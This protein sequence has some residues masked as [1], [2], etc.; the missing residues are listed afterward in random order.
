MQVRS[1]Q[2]RRPQAGSSPRSQRALLGQLLLALAGLA[3]VLPACSSTS[4]PAGPAGAPDAPT[5]SAEQVTPAA[6]TVAPGDKAVGISPTAPVTVTA[7]NGTLANVVMTNPEGAPVT[8][9]IAPDRLRW[10]P[11]EPLGY[12]KT[13]TV[14]ATAMGVDGTPVTTVSS[15]TTVSPDTLTYPSINPL[16]GETVGVGQPAV[17]IFDEPIT[18]KQAAE[19]S[20]KIS[21]EPPVAGAFYWYSDSE[22]HWR[23]EQY[24][25]P[26]TRVTMD[27]AVYGK[28]LGG[29]VFGEEDRR[30]TFTIGDALI[31]RADGASYQMSVEINGAV[32]R[33]MPISLGSPEFPSYNGTHIV[34]DQHTQYR[35]DSRSY[36]LGLDEG[37]YITDVRY[38]SRIS[39]SGEFLH[40][41][42]WS[43]G[44]QGQDNVSHGCINVSTENAQWFYDTAKK[45]DIVIITNSGGPDLPGSDGLGDWQIPWPEWQAGGKT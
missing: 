14:N 42:P 1:P 19:D 36:G 34:G 32:V 25:T 26:G 43:V 44:D 2:V 16:D 39:F 35:M 30:A 12:G 15:F 10:N 9:A 33:T 28:D 38:A 23:P 24:W 18:D 40:A 22:V 7:A 6:I 3:L 5:R 17:V 13:Y 45:G 4:S 20:I 8:G 41:A 37:G 11:T 21:T 31:A 27:V 29:G